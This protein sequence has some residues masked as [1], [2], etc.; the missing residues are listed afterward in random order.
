MCGVTNSPRSRPW[1]QRPFA[2]PALAWGLALLG[3]AGTAPALAYPHESLPHWLN[4]RL[5][6]YRLDAV[7][8]RIENRPQDWND[9]PESRTLTRQLQGLIQAGP[10]RY[11]ICETPAAPQGYPAAKLCGSGFGLENR[12]VM[13][14]RGQP[15]ALRALARYFATPGGGSLDTMGVLVSRQDWLAGQRLWDQVGGD[16]ALYRIT[17]ATYLLLPGTPDLDDG[18]AIGRAGSADLLTHYQQLIALRQALP[19]IARG[20]WERAVADG[21]TL[22]IQ[23]RLGTEHTVVTYNY[24]SAAARLALAGLPPG[25]RLEAAH[26]LAAAALQADARGQASVPLAPQSFAVWRVRAAAAR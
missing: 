24:G 20:S 3:G 15:E 5:D 9:R 18:E 11:V 21:A 1:P 23:R 17:A 19:S 13:A 14:A 22:S 7:P 12:L 8:H 10:Q 6:G 26:P 16:A 25:A 4:H 2:V